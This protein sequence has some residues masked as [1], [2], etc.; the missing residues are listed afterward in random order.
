[1]PGQSRTVVYRGC[2]GF[3][4]PC[5]PQGSARR[6]FSPANDLAFRSQLRASGR[7]QCLSALLSRLIAFGGMAPLS[8][9]PRSISKQCSTTWTRW[10]DGAEFPP[11]IVFYD[12]TNYWLA[13]GF[14]RVKAAEQAGFDEITCELYQGTQHDAQWYSFAANKTNG[15]R[16]TND[17]KQRAVKSALMHPNGAGLSDRQIGSH[18]GVDHKTVAALAEKLEGT[19]EIPQSEQTH[20]KRRPHKRGSSPTGARRRNRRRSNPSRRIPAARPSAVS[21]PEI[22]CRP[23]HTATDCKCRVMVSAGSGAKGCIAPR[24]R[25][26]NARCQPTI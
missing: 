4:R 23:R 9:A 13:D 22:L 1:M 16:R 17:D 2:A 20:W 26:A 6:Y 18:V 7:M 21:W 19:G 12:G 8:R 10:S 14:H 25:S 3:G 15:L 5:S 24:W 11:V